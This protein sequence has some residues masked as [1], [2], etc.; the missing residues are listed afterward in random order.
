ML[1]LLRVEDTTFSCFFLA[2][3]RAIVDD[4]L[5][6]DK[7]KNYLSTHDGGESSDEV[8]EEGQNGHHETQGWGD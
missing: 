7:D 8:N 2:V 6:M 3:S 5:K 4:V 1:L